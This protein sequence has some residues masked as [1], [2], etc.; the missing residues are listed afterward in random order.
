MALGDS[1][2]AAFGLIGASGGIYE[3]RGQSWAIGADKGEITVPNFF[4]HFLDKPIIGGSLK[5]H[6]VEVCIGP[7]LCPDHQYWPD[8]DQLNAAQSGAWVQNLPYQ[9][10]FLKKQLNS[11]KNINV[12]KDWKVLTILIGANNLCD[13]CLES[14]DEYDS[15]RQFEKSL[16]EV[17]AQLQTIPRVFVNLVG[18]FNISSVYEISLNNSYCRTMHEIL[19]FECNCAF[20]WFDGAAKRKKMDNVAAAY[21][22]VMVRVAKET[23]VTD[24]FALIYQP[25]LAKMVTP[26]IQFLSSLDCFHPSREAHQDLAIGLWNTML[27][28]MKD[29]PVDFIYPVPDITCPKN[30][31]LIYTY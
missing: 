9:I 12:E 19:F 25:M 27:L 31:T 23:P 7:F 18:I 13:A 1:I 11:N 4:N 14:F 29:K 17:V 16:R 6:I 21:R 15:A 24:S 10:E 28:P 3:Y 30:D 26:G 20:N 5:S 2:T 8:L 22:E